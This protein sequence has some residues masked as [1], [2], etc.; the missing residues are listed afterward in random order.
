MK[1]A[2]LFLMI[3]SVPA[4]LFLNAWQVFQFQARLGEVRQLES[5]QRD[6]IDQNRRALIGIEILSSPSRIEEIVGEM[7]DIEKRSDVPR[8]LIRVGESLDGGR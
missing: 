6:L 1:R 8:V 4:L 2:A 3:C 7:D 5:S